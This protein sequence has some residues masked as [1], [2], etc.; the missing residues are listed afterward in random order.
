MSPGAAIFALSAV[1]GLLL[2]I[3]GFLLV[4]KRRTPEQKER[5]RR[6][7]LSSNGRLENAEITEIQGVL[8]GYSY[9]VGGVTYHVVQDLTP[10][11]DLLPRDPALLL[12]PAAIKYSQSNPANSILLSEGWSGI[13]IAR[14][15]TLAKQKGA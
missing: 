6:L 2:A 8:A 4:G 7:L 10:F 5:A 13:R 3:A 9:E 12:G 15:D 14:P 11:R 1:G